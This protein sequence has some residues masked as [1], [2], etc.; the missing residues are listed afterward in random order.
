[1]PTNP[2]EPSVIPWQLRTERARCG[3]CQAVV[4]GTELDIAAHVHACTKER[5]SSLHL[6]ASAAEMGA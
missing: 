3:T 4:K 5:H 2:G 6:L 1:M